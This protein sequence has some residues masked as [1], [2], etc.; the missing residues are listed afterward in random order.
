MTLRAQ[1][2]T[3]ALLGTAQQPLDL[4][5]TGTVLDALLAQIGSSEPPQRLLDAAALIVPYERSGAKPVAALTTPKVAEEDSRPRCS[6]VAAGHLVSLLADRRALLPEWLSALA[7][8][9]QRPPEEAVP[10]LLDVAAGDRTIREAVLRACGSL[11]SWLAP[12]R[13]EW[14]WV[15][16]PAVDASVWETGTTDERITLLMQLRPT[17]PERCRELVESSWPTESAE[18]K[19][20][21]VDAFAT[22]LSVAD[23]PFLELV[24]DDRS[25]VARRGAAELLASL[26]ESRLVERMKARLAGRIRVTRTGLLGRKT[27]LEL[28]P[29]TELDAAMTRDGVEK[30]PSTASGLGERAWW[31]VQAISAVPPDYWCELFRLKP[32][33]LLEAAQNSDWQQV[34]AAGWHRAAVRHRSAEWLEAFTSFEPEPGEAVLAIFRVMPDAA[35]ER[36][37]LRLLR[38]DAKKWLPNVPAYCPHAWSAKFTEEFVDRVERNLSKDLADPL[39]WHIRSLL[40]AASVC[41]SPMAR[42]PEDSET[43]A[44]F[45][46]T[47]VFRRNM[48]NA[49]LSPRK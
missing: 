19:R 16:A 32:Q 30:K 33:D 13:E 44:E 24:L 27:T 29:F 12:F 21:F 49:I 14:E 36:V 28:D 31:T 3:A 7:E 18:N 34:L 22:G 39:I 11:A 35:R 20:R 40:R 9:G 6:T 10:L 37:M 38:D 43:F 17:D 15:T 2:T 47:L 48:R 26:A 25:I 45:T 42:W 1:L 46:D 5:L 41:A 23:E 4:P 8:A